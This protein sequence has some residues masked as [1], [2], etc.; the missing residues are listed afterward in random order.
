VRRGSLVLAVVAVLACAGSAAALTPDDPTWPGA[1]GQKRVGMAAAWDLTTGNP[2]VIVGVV[3]T[4]VDPSVPDIKGQLVP[5]WDFISN[6]WTRKDLGG[7]GTLVAS[8]IAGHGND[9]TGVAGYCWRCKVMPVRVS[10]DGDT[11]DGSRASQ[12]IRWA[13]DHGARVLSLSFSDQGA[14]AIGDSS[15]RSAIAYAAQKGVPVFASA[16]NSSSTKPTHPASDPGAYAVAATDTS[17]GLFWWSTRGSWVPLAAPG[18]QWGYWAGRGYMH[19]CGSSVS[20]PAVAGIAALML[21]VNPRLTPAQIVSALRQTSAPVAG[22][23]GGRVDAYRAL[24]A[25]GAKPPPPPPTPPPPPPP[26]T[27]PRPP[28]PVRPKMTT[29]VRRGVLRVHWHARVQVRRGRLAA[30]LRSPKAKSCTVSLRSSDAV[31]LN[32]VHRRNVTSLAAR[33]A[34]GRY[35]VEVWCRVRTPRKSQLLLRAIFAKS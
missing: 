1:W 29:R 34:A 11:Y 21:S 33:V 18:C 13:V 6:E 25:V 14:F 17:D 19:A 30:T 16:G 2:S 27:M 12:G 28:K 9:G 10:Y 7:H 5:G 20:A 24:L 23:A 15:V 32:N 8:I 4:G 35:N 31:W 26:T 22:I 3:D